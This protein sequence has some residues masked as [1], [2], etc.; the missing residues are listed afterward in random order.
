[1]KSFLF[2]TNVKGVFKDVKDTTKD[3]KAWH[4]FQLRPMLY[5]EGNGVQKR[6]V[7]YDFT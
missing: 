3:M 4:K 7:Y 1:M 5:W 2:P 6:I